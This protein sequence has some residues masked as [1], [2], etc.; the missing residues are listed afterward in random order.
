MRARAHG[1]EIEYETSGVPGSPAVVLVAGFS[2]QLTAWDPRFCEA[3]AARG[4]FVVRFDSR[5]VGLSTKLEGAPRPKIPAII[6]GDLSTMAY[7]IADMADDTAGLIEALGLGGAT[8]VGVS[9][10]GMIAQTLAIRRPDLVKGLVSI[11]STP[12]D[13]AVGQ[14]RPDTLA[15]VMQ[16]SPVDRA[17]NIEHGLRVWQKIRSPGFPYDDAL[18]R[19]RIGR[20]FDRSFYP[21]GVARQAAAIVGQP[22][23][24]PALAQLRLPTTVIHGREDT[25]IDV[26]GGEATARAIPGAKLV[27]VPGMGHDLPEGLWPVVLDAIAEVAK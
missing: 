18:G 25:L 8:V 20:S 6:G 1:L 26:S 12:G 27:V 22:D 13:R 10:G 4:F 7:G 16:R 3:L 23:R 11:M 9:M 15:L 17:E 24:T 14:A 19:E 2:Q 5:D 21:E